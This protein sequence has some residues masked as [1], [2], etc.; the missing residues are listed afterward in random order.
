VPGT[1]R[2]T[3]QHSQFFN[4]SNSLQTEVNGQLREGNNYQIEGI[5]DNER[6]GLL[7]IIIPPLEAIQTVDVSTSNFDAELGRASGAV[8]N[9]ILKSGT[10][11]YHGAAYEFIKNSYFNARNFF[12]AKRDLL[13]RNQY[14]FTIGGPVEIPKLYNGKDKTFWFFGYQGTRTRQ[15]PS[16]T[17]AFVPTPAMLN[18]DD[19]P[20]GEMLAVQRP[21]HLVDDRGIEISA[22]QEVGMQRVDRAAFRRC[23]GR[24]QSLTQHLAAENLRTAD[25]PAFAAEQVQL[26]PFESHH[27]DQIVE[28]LIHQIPPECASDSTAATPKRFCMMGL[29]VVYCRNCRFSGNKWCWMANAVS[30]ASWKPLKMSFFLPG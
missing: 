22:A 29:V 5:D 17:N 20:R 19:P 13:K 23:G 26:E 16:T 25:V 3:F 9:I 4:A 30:A 24:D 6:T 18:G 2:A 8:T 15:D 14:G 7:Q 11:N 1:T 28:Q 21:V 27:L 12:A 10:N